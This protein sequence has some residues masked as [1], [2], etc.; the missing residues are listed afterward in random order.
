MAQREE[1]G[2][3]SGMSSSTGMRRII[4]VAGVVALAIAVTAPVASGA[5]PKTRRISV[6]SSGAQ[7]HGTSSEPSISRNG[8]FTA[9]ESVASD[10]VA[11][12]LG[13]FKDV[14]VRDRK[15]GTTTLI[16]RHSNGTQGNGDSEDAA[17]SANGR[18]VAFESKAV[19]FV[20]VDANGPDED[21]FVH[22]RVTG[23][24]TL[25]SRHS[26]GTQ[27]DANSTDPA[28]SATGRFVA[29]ESRATNLAPG[30]DNGVKHVYVHD[31]DTGETTLVSRRSNGTVGNGDSG[32]PTISADGVWVAFESVAN[33]LV[34]GD[35]NGKED[36]FLHNRATGRTILVSRRPNG[37]PGNGDSGEPAISG[38]GRFVAFDSHAKNLVKGDKN[39]RRDVFV[40]DRKTKK[41]VLVSRNSNGRLGNDHSQEPSLSDNGRWVEFHSDASNLVKNDKNGDEDVFV[42]DR[43]TGKTILISRRPNGASGDRGSDDGVISG[44]GRFVAFES[45][46]TN[47]IKGDTNGVQDVFIRGPLR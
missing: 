38:N 43:R 23:T 4:A 20:D 19:N 8:R 25:V 15:L 24:T 27:G 36:V 18:I 10:L 1:S 41:V 11:N 9:F 34:N 28:L 42:R 46:A 35:G 33:N 21:V 7:A 44:D 17:I 13:G 47:L 5:N 2:M 14:F 30:G 22:D 45:D 31:R 12:D 3:G 29:F 26:N 32:S 16:S 6:H 37:A 40:F 39:G